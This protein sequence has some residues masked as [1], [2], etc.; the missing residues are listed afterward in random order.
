MVAEI[1]LWIWLVAVVVASGC[2]NG[3]GGTIVADVPDVRQADEQTP[4]DV[5]SPACA[6]K[7]C[8]DDGCGGSCGQCEMLKET[9]S[10]EGQCIPAPCQSSLDC[11]SNLVCNKSSGECVVCLGDEDCPEGTTCGADHDC[12]KPYPCDSDKDCKELGLVCDKQAGLCVQCLGPEECPAEEYCLGGYCVADECSAGESKCV[13]GA[14]ET[15]AAD[16]SGWQVSEVCGADQHCLDGACHDNVCPPGESYC[17]DGV[18]KTCDAIGSAVTSEEN[19][20]AKELNCYKGECLDTVCPAGEAFCEDDFTKAQCAD[21]GLTYST[22]PCGAGQYCEA[23]GC[24]PQVC[25]PG[26][27]FCQDNAVAVCNGK[28]SAVQSTTDCGALVCVNGGCHELVCKPGTTYC[29]GKV[30]MACD[31]S[32]T[33]AQTIEACGDGQ[34]CGEDGSSASCQDQVC[35]PGTLSC[36]GTTIVE[37]DDLGASW[38]PGDD[39]A[40]EEMGCVDGECVEDTVCGATVCPSLP[41]YAVCCNSRGHCEYASVQ[42]AGWHAWD[43]WILVPPGTFTMGSPAEQEGHQADE[44]PVHEVSIEHPYLVGKYEVT[45]EQYEACQADGECSQPSTEDWDAEGWGTNSSEKGRSDHPQNGLTWSQANTICSWLAPGGRLPSEAEWEY[46]AAGP[47]H[48]KYPWGDAPE[49]TCAAGLAVFNEQGGVQGYGC[50]S[51]GTR[52]VGEGPAGVAWCGAHDMAGNVWE[53][54]LD[55]YHDNY[56]GAPADGS[57]WLV[58]T[59]HRS[60]RGGSFYYPSSYLRTARRTKT[61]PNNKGA[62]D[63]VRC[64]WPVP[65]T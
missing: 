17:E 43:V 25:D 63:G 57:P 40:D 18:A 29:D 26:A 58:P 54:C 7:E 62:S 3:N 4:A 30:V 23:G 5:C 22:A 45:V 65:G 20:E 31:E 50:G 2:S 64:V 53:W 49:P 41:G 33:A 1:R 36:D 61:L 24:K 13:E 16:G 8:G 51:G 11:P 15:C 59:A 14:V 56:V 38:L 37:C 60:A 52:P 21:D 42:V 39:C 44:S 12:H 35:T 48:W 32:G 34:Y 47:D 9:C 10:D 19:C 46:A 55:W 27:T 6:G 28:G